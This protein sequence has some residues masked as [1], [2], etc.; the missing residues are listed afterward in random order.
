MV[1]CF[2]LEFGLRRAQEK[3][4]VSSGTGWYVDE[5]DKWLWGLFYYDPHDRRDHRE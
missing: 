2:R 1:V 3:L 4:T 5:D